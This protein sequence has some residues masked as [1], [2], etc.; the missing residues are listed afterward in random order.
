MLV[1]P[2]MVIAGRRRVTLDLS[3]RPRAGDPH[4]A[5]ACRGEV[6]FNGEAWTAVPDLAVRA[7]GDVDTR[8]VAAATGERLRF[9]IE[10]DGVTGAHAAVDLRVRLD[11]E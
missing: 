3:I 7:S 1:T 2:E 9:V 6:T 5:V 11:S 8:R 10:P 4:A